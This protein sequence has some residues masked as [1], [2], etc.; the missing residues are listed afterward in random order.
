MKDMIRKADVLIEALP[1]IQKFRGEIVVVKVGGSTMEEKTGVERVLT[2]IAFMACV[3]LRPVVVH[4]GGKAISRAMKEKGLPATFVKGLRVTDEAAADVVEQ[5]LNREVNPDIVRT[6]ERLGCT[7][8]GIHGEDIL[9]VI[10]HTELDSETGEALDW[11]FVGDVVEVDDDP[12]LAYLHAHIV[13]VITPLGWGPDEKVYNINADDAASA[14]AQALKARKLVYLSDVPG[15]LRDPEDNTTL[16]STLKFADVDKL[17]AQG[18]ISGGMI[19][20]VLGAVR[21]IKAGVRKVHF[22]DAKLPHSLLLELFT[23]RGVGTEIVKK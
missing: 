18:V 21:A 20:K 22:I 8:R 9:D 14:I 13:P 6:L 19:P 17:V 4:G 10:K 23:D 12:I 1:H 3:G 2:D 16:I 15:L 7:A 5:V 11:G